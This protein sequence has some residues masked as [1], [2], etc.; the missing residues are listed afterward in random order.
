LKLEEAKARLAVT[1]ASAA[2]A[3]ESLRLVKKQ[4]EG[5]SA[6][7]TR[8]LDTELSLNRA[9]IRSTAAFYD[10]EKTRAAVGRA[11]GYWGKYAGETFIGNE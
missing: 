1:E 9:R 7:I 10:R 3:E 6:T 4:Y 5:G 8:Y 2:Q 11:L